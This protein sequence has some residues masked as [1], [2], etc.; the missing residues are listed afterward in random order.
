MITDVSLKVAG[1]TF[2]E[3][4]SRHAILRNPSAETLALPPDFS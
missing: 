2:Q 1:F 3:K 4:F